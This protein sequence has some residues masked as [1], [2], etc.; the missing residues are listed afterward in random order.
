MKSVVR[1]LVLPDIICAIAI[2][3][4]EQFDS[5]CRTCLM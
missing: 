5:P 4:Q 3:S 1:T 2:R